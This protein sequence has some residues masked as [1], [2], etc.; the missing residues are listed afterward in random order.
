MD[1]IIRRV[2]RSGP[3]HPEAAENESAAGDRRQPQWIRRAQPE[4]SGENERGEAEAD[5]RERR[6]EPKSRERVTEQEQRRPERH[7]FAWP[8]AAEEV[9]PDPAEGVEETERRQR[10]ERKSR[11]GLNDPA[12]KGKRADDS[13]RVDEEPAR[14]NPGRRERQE[15][16]ARE[17]HRAP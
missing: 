10:S 15:N 14:A 3:P 8:E 13:D 9:R 5:R 11:A 12:K 4:I 16:V 1:N 7:L 6:P 17:V 2:H